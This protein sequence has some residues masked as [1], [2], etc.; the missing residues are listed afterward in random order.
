MRDLGY[1]PCLADPD[2]WWKANVRADRHEYYEYVLLYVDDVLV[3]SHKPHEV[4]RQINKFF[5]LK[6]GSA[7]PPNI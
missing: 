5:P 7:G 1:E 6:K 3:I 4:L 2:L